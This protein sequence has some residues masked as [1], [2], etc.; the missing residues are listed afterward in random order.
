MSALAAA[1]EIYHAAKDDAA[2]QAQILAEYK[3]AVIAGVLTKGGMDMIVNA[4]KNGS[5]MTMIREL[6]EM[7]RI[8]SLRFAL[9]WIDQGCAP[10]S[11]RSL[12]RF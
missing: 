3:R 12:G 2:F 5:T 10:S 7:D 11:G 1:R 8:K 9:Q 6:G 4:S